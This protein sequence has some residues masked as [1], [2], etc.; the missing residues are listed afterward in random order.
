[1]NLSILSPWVSKAA[2]LLD[3]RPKD[4]DLLLIKKACEINKHILDLNPSID[5]ADCEAFLS[6]CHH[7]FAF[8]DIFCAMP[9]LDIGGGGGGYPADAAAQLILLQENRPRELAADETF[10]LGYDSLTDAAIAAVSALHFGTEN[11]GMESA[12]HALDAIA[13]AEQEKAARS[14]AEF[15]NCSTL[16]DDI[17]FWSHFKR[18]MVRMQKYMHDPIPAWK[19]QIPTDYQYCIKLRPT[20]MPT[21]HR[22]V[23]F[24]TV[25]AEDFRSGY[26]VCLDAEDKAGASATNWDNY[27][28]AKSMVDL[29][30][31]G[32]GSADGTMRVGDVRALVRKAKQYFEVIKDWMPEELKYAGEE[33]FDFYGIYPPADMP[34]EAKMPGTDISGTG[35]LEMNLYGGVPNMCNGCGKMSDMKLLKCSGCETVLYCGKECQKKDWKGGHNLVCRRKK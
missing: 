14:A 29:A 31:L 12:T 26:K 6:Y 28:L 7:V 1:M 11:N 3:S 22:L 2:R 15:Y 5:L 32:A 17:L 8:Y 4:P 25:I 18:A 21:Y 24:Y 10:R 20:Y 30:M 19:T 13:N 33:Q 35:P 16:V 23:T 9:P 27:E 34:D